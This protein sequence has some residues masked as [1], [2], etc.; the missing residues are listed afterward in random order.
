MTGRDRCVYFSIFLATSS[1][2]VTP[3]DCVMKIERPGKHEKLT[4]RVEGFWEV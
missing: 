1:S 2:L 3:A 4:V